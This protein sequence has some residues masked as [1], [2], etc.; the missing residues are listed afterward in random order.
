MGDCGVLCLQF[1]LVCERKDLRAHSNMMMMAGFLVGS[2]V[3]SALC[4]W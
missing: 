4:D 3:A 1:D 2:T